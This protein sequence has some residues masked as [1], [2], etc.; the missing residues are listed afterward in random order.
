MCM[1][2]WYDNL[3]CIYTVIR[4]LLVKRYFRMVSPRNLFSYH[5][6]GE[7]VAD[8][9]SIVIRFAGVSHRRFMAIRYKFNLVTYVQRPLVIDRRGGTDRNLNQI[10]AGSR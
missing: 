10:T 8:H 3:F 5:S 7:D 2:L 4:L 6:G 1:Y 9:F